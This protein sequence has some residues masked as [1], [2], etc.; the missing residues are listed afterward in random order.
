MDLKTWAA[1]T[2]AGR[3]HKYITLE[4][5]VKEL[6]RQVVEMEQKERKE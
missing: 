1:L 3:L 6:R 5:T 4:R 2:D